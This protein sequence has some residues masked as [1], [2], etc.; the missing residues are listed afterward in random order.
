MDP[1]P[2]APVSLGQ[3]TGASLEQCKKDRENLDKLVKGY[4]GEIDSLEAAL[5]EAAARQARAAN[6]LAATPTT[7]PSAPSWRSEIALQ[8]NLDELP[9]LSGIENGD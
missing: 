2:R 7:S 5:A 8:P 6:R 3:E 4:T 1:A 9:D